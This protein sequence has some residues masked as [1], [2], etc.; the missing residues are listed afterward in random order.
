MY[1]SLH[2]LKNTLAVYLM[3]DVKKE[4][5]SLLLQKDLIEHDLVNMKNVSVCVIHYI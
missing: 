1:F 5:L 4:L 2:A 3:K